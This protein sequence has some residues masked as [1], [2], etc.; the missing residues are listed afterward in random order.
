MFWNSRLWVHK[1]FM[2]LF[3]LLPAVMVDAAAILTGRDPRWCKAYNLINNH[4]IATSY[5][6]TEQWYFKNDQFNGQTVRT[7]E[8]GGSLARSSSLT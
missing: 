1:I 3:H 2:W 6:M 8:R 4:L 5:F 7:N